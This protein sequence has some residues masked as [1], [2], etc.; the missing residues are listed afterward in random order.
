[1]NSPTFSV[2]IPA[3]NVEAYIGETL[4]SVFKQTFSDFEIIV[5]NDGS[6]DST[7][8]TIH[9]F[10]DPRLRLYNVNNGGVSRARNYGIDLAQG[11]YIA[12]LDGDDIWHESHLEAA[13]RF[14]SEHPDIKWY[15]S[16]YASAP[17][18]S[19]SLMDLNHETEVLPYFGKPAYHVMPTTLIVSTQAAKLIQPFFPTNMVNAEDWVAW[20]R[21]AMQ[22][23][24]IGFS[25][26]IDS[27]YRS[28]P[29]SSSKENVRKQLFDKYHAMSDAFLGFM[30][31]HT[32]SV[33]ESAYYRARLLE[34][35]H[36][37]ICLSGVWTWEDK[38]REQKQIL[39]WWR[40]L[41]IKFS[42][43]L[44]T[45]ARTVSTHAMGR[46]LK[47]DEITRK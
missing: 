16:R 3:Y 23:P 33:Q 44:V 31:E 11:E 21:L 42:L 45:F 12:F 29:D 39:G 18:Y 4:D 38:L 37:L 14:F 9:Q 22:Y 7:K 32:P 17:A 20:A 43:F 24:L 30:K 13:A 2:V 35:W 10:H 46:L 26:R 1:M 8:E 15:S 34:R 36:I 41:V 40:Y 19:V 47:V 27:L 25:E 28:R 5:V 6:T